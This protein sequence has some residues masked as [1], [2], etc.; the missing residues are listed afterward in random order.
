MQS[1]LGQLTLVNQFNFPKSIGPMGGGGAGGGLLHGAALAGSFTNFHPSYLQQPSFQQPPAAVEPSSSAALAAADDKVELVKVSVTLP[2]L[3]P[4]TAADPG[5]RYGDW[6][7]R[8][9][10]TIGGMTDIAS[11]WWDA[12]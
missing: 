12:M 5:V 4:P 1:P 3:E 2:K 8:A 6:V 10:L 11:V 9:G 7:T